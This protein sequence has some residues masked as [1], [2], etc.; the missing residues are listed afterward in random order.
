[1]MDPHVLGKSDS[2]KRLI[3]AHKEALSSLLHFDYL[4]AV[5]AATHRATRLAKAMR[6]FFT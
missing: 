2:V 3:L 4:A 5:G 1:M 6:D